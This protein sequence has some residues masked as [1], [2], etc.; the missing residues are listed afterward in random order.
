MLWIGASD[1]GH[2][3]LWKWVNGAGVS[4]KNG[5]WKKGEPNG[6]RNEN[7]L[8]IWP[9]KGGKWNDSRCKNKWN[10]VCQISLTCV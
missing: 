6:R 2:E 1:I 9:A 4:M 10:F 7:C 5:Y 8:H 3:G